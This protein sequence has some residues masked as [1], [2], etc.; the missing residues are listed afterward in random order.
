MA[1]WLS[2]NCEQR[3]VNIDGEIKEKWEIGLCG[4][5]LSREVG[6]Y[7]KCTVAIVRRCKALCVVYCRRENSYLKCREQ[8]GWQAQPSNSSE[9]AMITY[10]S[11]LTQTVWFESENQRITSNL[12]GRQASI[13]VQTSAGVR[14]DDCIY[15]PY[16]EKYPFPCRKKKSTKHNT[17]SRETK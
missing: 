15:L 14:N 4:I 17:G 1:W 6:R 10:F 7:K 13:S 5:T 2:H 16:Q 9:P 12:A 3:S 11:S 8:H